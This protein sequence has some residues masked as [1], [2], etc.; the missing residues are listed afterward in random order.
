MRVLIRGGT[1]LLGRA[2]VE[3]WSLDEVAGVGSQ[4]ADLRDVG[5]LRRVF[6]DKRPD[7]TV[8]AA[9]YTDVDGCEKNPALARAVN[10]Q[11]AA[12]AAVVAREFGSR[13][14]IVSTDY[15]FDGRNGR[16]HEVD[17]PVCPLNVYGQSKA[18]GADPRRGVLPDPPIGPTPCLFG[19]H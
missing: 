12:N 6:S 18:D 9:A 7:W 5:Q 13:L 4:E 8:L 3:E 11:G 1:G 14:L 19:T 10:T 17:D 2:L 15:V 16:P